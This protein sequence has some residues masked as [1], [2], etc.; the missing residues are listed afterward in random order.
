MSARVRGC[1]LMFG[2]SWT[3][4]M[5]AAYPF[6]SWLSPLVTF[7]FWLAAGFAVLGIGL[8][9]VGL[10]TGRAF[11]AGGPGRTIF[12]GAIALRPHEVKG[13][14]WQEKKPSEAERLAA[15]TA[16]TVEAAVEQS[17]LEREAEHDAMLRGEVGVYGQERKP[18][19]RDKY[20][21]KTEW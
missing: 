17:R 5:A 3:N 11:G 4:A 18:V 12:G 2:V 13:A 10:A 6:A 20:D 21:Y 14:A 9:L 16:P 1:G 8:S 15:A 7:F 19:G